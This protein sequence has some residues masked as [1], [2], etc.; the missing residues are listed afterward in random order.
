MSDRALLRALPPF[1]RVSGEP[2]GRASR[3]LFIFGGVE[4]TGGVPILDFAGDQPS[5]RKGHPDAERLQ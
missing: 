5:G 1:W 2:K 4:V 3:D